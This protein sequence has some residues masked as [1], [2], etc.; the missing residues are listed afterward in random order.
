MED[1]EN[2]IYQHQNK[3]L[4]ID[5]QK[6]TLDFDNVSS[7]LDRV[8]SWWCWVGGGVGWGGSGQWAGG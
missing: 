2:G 6:T 7:V 1:F 4:A 5:P 3:P 8:W